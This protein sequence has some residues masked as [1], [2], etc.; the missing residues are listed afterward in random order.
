MELESLQAGCLPLQAH[1]SQGGMVDDSNI[2]VT[3]LKLNDKGEELLATLGIFF[4]EV[5]GGC[6]CHDDPLEV[7]AY[8]ELELC[9]DK[10]TAVATVK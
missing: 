7:N 3:V 6:N 5:V 1:T 2:S 4:T 8:A 10:Q 9:I